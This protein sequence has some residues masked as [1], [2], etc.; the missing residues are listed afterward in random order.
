MPQRDSERGGEMSVIYVLFWQ[1]A[2]RKKKRKEYM[3]VPKFKEKCY[4]HNIFS[5]NSK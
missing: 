4:V 1:L 5:I 2:F 3:V